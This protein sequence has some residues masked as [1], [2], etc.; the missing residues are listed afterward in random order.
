VIVGTHIVGAPLRVV[1]HKMAAALFLS[2]RFFCSRGPGGRPDR[3]CALSFYPCAPAQS[4]T[5]TS[6]FNHNN[7]GPFRA[8]PAILRAYS[9]PLVPETTRRPGNRLALPA[10]D[11]ITLRVCLPPAAAALLRPGAV[12][13]PSAHAGSRARR[14]CPCS[15]YRRSRVFR[16]EGRGSPMDIGP[17]LPDIRVLKQ[18]V[19]SLLDECY[20]YFPPAPCPKWRRCSAR[21]PQDRSGRSGQA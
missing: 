6:L 9:P 11:G 20:V 5:M 10:P 12:W 7:N 4:P 18:A 1:S 19:A 8:T 2:L 14:C 16:P 15:R 13:R 21:C 17:C 3:P